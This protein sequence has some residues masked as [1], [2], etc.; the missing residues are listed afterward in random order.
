MKHGISNNYFLE[1]ATDIDKFGNRNFRAFL[2]CT[3]R[4]SG[5]YEFGN[6]GETISSVLGKNQKANTLS[7]FGKLFAWILDKLDKKHCEKSIEN[8]ELKNK[9]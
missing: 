8:F 6:V 3:M 5:G 1:T 9:N 2:N 4:I 7:W